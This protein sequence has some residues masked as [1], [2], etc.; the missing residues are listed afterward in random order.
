MSGRHL[1]FPAG[2][3]MH[4][5]LSPCG[6]CV[7]GSLPTWEVLIISLL[8]RLYR[9]PSLVTMAERGVVACF[10]TVAGFQPF[11]VFTLTASPFLRDGRDLAPLSK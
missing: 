11:G 1:C 7:Q 2:N 3:F 4:A 5:S 10:V 9:V 8:F 6:V